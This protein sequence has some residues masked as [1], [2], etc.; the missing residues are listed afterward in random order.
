MLARSF[1]AIGEDSEVDGVGFE[2]SGRW[3]AIGDGGRSLCACR[4]HMRCAPLKVAKVVV[5]KSR[6]LGRVTQ[7]EEMMLKNRIEA[8]AL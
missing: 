7:Y 1:D 3:S 4:S 6:K 2:G 5:W 8:L